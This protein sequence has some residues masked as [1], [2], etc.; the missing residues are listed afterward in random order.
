[1]LWMDGKLY[2]SGF[3]AFPALA[4]LVTAG[5]SWFYREGTWRMEMDGPGGDNHA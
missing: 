4:V 3:L 1:L 5:V 2:G